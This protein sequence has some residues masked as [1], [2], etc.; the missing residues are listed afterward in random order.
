[1]VDTGPA[2]TAWR[3]A[4]RRIVAS[5]EGKTANASKFESRVN[6]T[7]TISRA[8]ETVATDGIHFPSVPDGHRLACRS[9]SAYPQRRGRGRGRTDGYGL[10]AGPGG[11]P[12]V[13]SGP[14]QVWHVPGAAGA[15][16]AHPERR[17]DC[18]DTADRYPDLGG[19][20]PPAGGRHV[21]GTDLRAGLLRLLVRF[22]AR[23]VS[24][25]GVGGVVEADDGQPRGLDPGSGHPEIL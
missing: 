18:R 16:C 9:V 4:R 24:A 12:P 6:E 5:L 1:S 22:S 13:A 20:G 25:P 17:L 10:R 8:G 14:G 19:Q 2:R 23:A 11:Q 3:E 21:A 7:T 15:A